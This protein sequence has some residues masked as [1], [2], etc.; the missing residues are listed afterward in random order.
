MFRTF[1]FSSALSVLVCNSLG[2]Q[3]ERIEPPNW[4]VGM[5]E[6]RVQLLIKG[7]HIGDC[8]LR[9][10]HPGLRVEQLIRTPNENYLF[11]DLYVE[12]TAA[13]GPVKLSFSR[14]GEIVATYDWS[15]ESRDWAHPSYRGFDNSDVLYLITPD[16]F[17]N[18]NPANDSIAGMREAANRKNPDGRH[19]GDLAG[20]LKHLDYLEDLGVTGLWLNPVLENDM[21]EYSYHGYAATDFYRVD[22]RFGTNEDYRNLADEL[23]KRRMK[24]I[25]DMIVNHCGL[26]HWWMKD[27]PTPDW[28]NTWE[29]YTQTSHQ[30]SVIQDPYVAE[31][32]YKTYTDGWFVPTMPDLNQRQA[33]LANYLIQNSIWWVEYLGLAGIRMDTYSYS[34]QHFLTEW[35]RR[36]MQEYPQLNITGEEWS[37][38]P[39]IL[40]YWQAGKDNP[41]GYV[42]Y[43]PSLIDFPL[44]QALL[45]ALQHPEGYNQG[46]I[47]LYETLSRDHLYPDPYRLLVFPDNHDMARLYAQ[48]DEDVALVKLALAYILTTR[49]TPQ[50]YYGTEI[51]MN[52]PKE[53]H[54][55]LLRGDFPGGW[56]G[57]KV[58][59]FSGQG[60]SKASAEMQQWTRRLLNWRKHASAIHYG[61]LTHYQPKEGI[62]VYFRY[63]DTQRVMVVLNKNEQPTPLALARFTE[64]LAATQRGK[65]VLSEQTYPLREVLLVPPKQALIL[66]LE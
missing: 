47:E 65:D 15:L 19:G 7:D 32:D 55:G 30:K 3:I 49:G 14:A 36:L 13:K 6:P 58:N 33:L 17:A 31:I 64:H 41:N 35:T 21:P 42:S 45:K 8:Y 22:S 28:I 12:P 48:L 24:L 34:D 53:R 25:M 4:W 20:I 29:T 2:A 37:D 27:Y 26:E 63:H 39:V 62:Y 50:I 52:S 51:L 23:R 66:E 5:E 1:L 11:A 38:D 43:L 59:A 9:I 10:D 44:Q 60:L 57:D 46:W 56:P 18:G 40:A 16:R 54:D 61:K